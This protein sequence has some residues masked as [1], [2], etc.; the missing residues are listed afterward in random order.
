MLKRRFAS[1]AYKQNADICWYG[2]EVCL[3]RKVLSSL[4]PPRKRSC[5]KIMFLHLSVI[6]FTGRCL[7]LG[8]LG[9]ARFAEILT[10][11]KWTHKNLEFRHHR[12]LILNR[13]LQCKSEKIYRAQTAQN[14]ALTK[15]LHKLRETSIPLGRH[16]WQTPPGL[17]PHWADTT[18]PVEMTFDVGGTHPTGMH[19]CLLKLATV[20]VAI[21]RWYL[22]PWRV[23][24]FIVSHL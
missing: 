11:F 21:W 24:H 22:L 10:V 6:L 19:S 18:P 7:S 14:L 16:P 20:L 12:M 4:L 8:P 5:G 1:H 15:I 9:C 2:L 23:L 17:T 3:K 13:Q